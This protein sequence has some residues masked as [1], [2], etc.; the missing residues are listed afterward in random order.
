MTWRGE[1]MRA[2]LGN[3]RLVEVTPSVSLEVVDGS[4]KRREGHVQ[5]TVE[6]PEHQGVFCDGHLR[7]EV[8][9]EFIELR[10]ISLMVLVEDLDCSDERLCTASGD[11]I[12]GPV[13]MRRP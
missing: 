5:K 12:V 1:R 4:T 3:L 10:G 11:V 6:G 8:R 2:R 9:H 7:D 13:Q